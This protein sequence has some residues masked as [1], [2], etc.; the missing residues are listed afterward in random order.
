MNFEKEQEY[1]NEEKPW[2]E[3]VRKRL[4]GLGEKRRSFNQGDVVI[5]TNG[6]HKFRNMAVIR[7][8]DRGMFVLA[9]PSRGQEPIEMHESQLWH[10]D[11]YR[12]VL[13][14]IVLKFPEMI[15]DITD[16][17]NNEVRPEDYGLSSN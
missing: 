14:E 13:D 17:N 7:K 10:I 9:V 12:K 11:D 3:I 16:I 15:S 6:P 4:K 2:M 8:S 1:G 5:T